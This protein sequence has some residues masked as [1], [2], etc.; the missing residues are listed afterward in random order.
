MNIKINIINDKFT[1]ISPLAF[2][3]TFS[4]LSEYT[5]DE[6]PEK[7]FKNFGVMKG[8]KITDYEGTEYKIVNISELNKFENRS[9]E[10][11][12]KIDLRKL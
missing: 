8:K 2:G 9:D 5:V 10:T 4:N 6:T 3:T 11:V 1:S 7:T 12:Y